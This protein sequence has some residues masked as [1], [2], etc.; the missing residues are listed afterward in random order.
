MNWY[1]NIIYKYAKINLSS[2]NLEAMKQL[3]EKGESLKEMAKLF[4]VSMKT[5]YNII[6]RNNWK[7]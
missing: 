6:K 7:L 2:E 4:G 5:I 1:K 3:A